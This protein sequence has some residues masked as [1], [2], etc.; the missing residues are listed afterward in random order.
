MLGHVIYLI[1]TCGNLWIFLRRLLGMRSRLITINRKFT[2]S[3]VVFLKIS[4]TFHN[5]GVHL[6]SSSTAWQYR[7]V[8]KLQETEKS[9]EH[10]INSNL[11]VKVV[12][13]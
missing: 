11:V 3:F 10:V 9:I 12:S 1:G 13:V 6:S 4:Q 7:N 2:Y 8:A 5:L